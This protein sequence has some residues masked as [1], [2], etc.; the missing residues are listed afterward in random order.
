MPSDLK[1][2]H[3]ANSPY[4]NNPGTKKLYDFILNKFQNHLRALNIVIEFTLS[5]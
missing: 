4:W 1:E 2:Q 3:M 5:F